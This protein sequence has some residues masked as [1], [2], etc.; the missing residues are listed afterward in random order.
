MFHLLSVIDTCNYYPQRDG[1]IDEILS[2]TT[3]SQWVERR[4][5]YPVV[6]AFNN[7]RAQHLMELGRPAG[8]PGRIALPI[9]GGDPRARQVVLK[10][11]D[12]LGFDGVDAGPLSES[13]RQATGY[14]GLYHGPRRG[15]RSPG[16]PKR[17]QR[18]APGVPCRIMTSAKAAIERTV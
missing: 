13:W 5:G 15:R 9:S 17:E 4:L 2:G 3:E 8:T 12:E 6:K 10:L 14:A 16:P 7:I 1:R 18:A 11:C